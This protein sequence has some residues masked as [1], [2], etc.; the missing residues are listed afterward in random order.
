METYQVV[1]MQLFYMCFCVTKVLLADRLGQ[2]LVKFFFT[3]AIEPSQ[4]SEP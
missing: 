1:N 3:C 2:F 4:K